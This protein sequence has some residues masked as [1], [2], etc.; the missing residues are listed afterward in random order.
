MEIQWPLVLFTLL[1]GA[2][3]WVLAFVAANEFTGKS[4]KD[5]FK[6]ALVG[7]VL[8]VLGG[9]ASVLHLT[10]PDRIMNALSNPTS[11]IF[12]EAALVGIIS[13]CAIVQLILYKRGIA[14]AAKAFAVLSGLFGVVISFMAGESYIVMN[15]RAA[16][17]T[18]LLPLAYLGTAAPMGAGL[19]WALAAPDEDNGAAF[20]ALA[21]C[22]GGVLGLVL[23]LAYAA[24]AGL[25]G[26]A[27]L[28][29]VAGVAVLDAAVAVIGFLGKSKPTQVLAWASVALAVVAGLLLRVLMWVAGAGAYGFFG[30]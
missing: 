3:G 11:G 9:F 29:I 12:V 6:V 21:T 13:V 5:P 20:S 19:Y 24:V 23:T 22:V 10:H 15:S 1:T 2:G 18:V 17:D 27:A 4:K 26:G 7:L 16:W 30:D 25:F 14:G 8:V 28:G